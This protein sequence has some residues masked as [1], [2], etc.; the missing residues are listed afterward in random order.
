MNKR[1]TALQEENIFRLTEDE[2]FK[3]LNTSNKGL[4]HNEAETR[5]QK[6]GY[7]EINEVKTSSLIAKFLSNFTNLLA[8]L[9]WIA[10][11]LSFVGRMPQLGWTII[12]V[13]I[14]NALFS[15]WQEFKAEKATESLKK[16]LPQYVKVIRDGHLEQMLSK[17][18]VP[19]DLIS[20][21][22]GDHVPADARLMEA[23]EMR[24]INAAL[25]GESEPV[26]RSSDVV[27]ERDIT[28]LDA[29]NIVFMGTNVA[30][31]SGLAIVYATRMNTQFGKIASLTQNIKQEQSPLQK[32]LTNVAKFITYLS[33]VM[34]VLFFLFGL[35]MG[36]SI[37]DI[38]MFAIGI[39]T[40][41]VPE[42]LLPTVTLALAAGVQRMA[43]RNALVKKLSSV[44]TLG[45]ATIICTDKTG[46]L[47]QNEMTISEI[48]T[49]INHYTV[50]GI[51]Y[52]PK[53]EFFLGENKI[54]PKNLTDELSLLLKIGVLC[55]NSSIVRP[56]D[57]NPCWNV[58]GDPTE[59]AFVVLSEK[60]GFTKEDVLREF[61]LIYQLPFDSRR[62][63]MSTLHNSGKDTYVF[64]KGAPKEIISVCSD[65][66]YGKNEIKNLGQ[67]EIQKII[68]QNDKFAQD[69]LRVLAIAYKKI[70]STI[71]DYTIDNTE[72]N[73]IFV[74]LT[75]M[76]DPPRPEV[77]KAVKSAQ[78]AG[79][80]IIMIT[81]D[82]GLTAESIARKIGII[83]SLHPKII[84][85]NDLDK[86]SA[87]NLN[88]E[89]KNKEIIFARA[90]PEHKMRIVAALKE[91]GEVVAV[92]GDGV[93]DTPAL[94][95]AD[96]G[97][98]MGK[99]GTDI[100]REVA[101]MVLTN[102]NFASI[103]NAIEEGRAVY[104]NVR[105]FMTYIFAHL[106]PE[107]IPY[108]LFALFNIPIPITVMQILAID[109]GTETLPALSLGVELP[110]PGVMDR[111]PK[112]PNEKLLNF[113]VLFRGYILLGLI[114]TVAVL[115]GYFWVLYSGG[116][117]WGQILETTNP[118]SQKAATMSFLGIVIMQVANV[119]ACRTEV[120]SIFSIGL[121]TNK[122][123][124]VSVIFELVLTAAL[125]YI[126][127]LQK[128]FE[129]YPVPIAYWLFYIAFI[130]II[131]G[132]EEVRKWI[133][134]KK[135]NVNM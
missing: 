82:Y 111:P 88:Y 12:L 84:T 120:A 92:T 6:Y 49:P 35:I 130:P 122:L 83:K 50:S 19:G 77:E 129:T 24:T 65:I 46:T 48:W 56:S 105:K 99:S 27:L 20:L 43:K 113:S 38:F 103:V 28:L 102:D 117:H 100:A 115:S 70:D 14:I 68:G 8:I 96:I 91:M 128:I 18:L 126:P 110:E 40:A 80:K 98:A 41:N 114:S 107:V 5:I 52:E 59:G 54:D 134:R 64:T 89:L 109:I 71:R 58:I 31:G 25:T 90:A 21:E 123:L 97:I 104:D 16:L 125:I 76:M 29:P 108:I 44:E 69:G 127:F 75:A 135:L 66:F 61:P 60:A 101:T 23:F 73:M 42:G 118:L 62:K 34:G 37:A 33:L 133:I 67:E 17:Q 10:S 51:G 132:A 4:T 32:Q 93:N 11:I 119:F 2:I 86:L 63:R 13:I 36:R 124:N 55:N 57:G 45:G 3:E 87:E 95:M 9:L 72:N 74:G 22:E 121:L 106:T 30:S 94:K 39:I 112:P 53:G 1:V 7:N 26:L 116:W 81:G 85:G 131:I 79:I 78:N 47:T 15:F